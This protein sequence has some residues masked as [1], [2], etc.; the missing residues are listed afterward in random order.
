MPANPQRDIQKWHERLGSEGNVDSH[1]LLAGHPKT[2]P[3]EKVQR[4]IELLKNHKAAG[5]RN[6]YP[7]LEVLSLKVPEAAE[8][9][10]Q[11]GISVEALCKRIRKLRPSM[12]RIKVVVKKLH[13][14]QHLQRRLTAAKS[15]VRK[16][17]RE[18][19][20][21][22]FLDSKVMRME[23][24]E[25]YGWVDT[26]DEEDV[27]EFKRAKSRSSRVPT[28]NYYI[29]VGG[30]IGACDLRFCTGTTGMKASREG[31]TFKVS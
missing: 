15:R 3:D 14:P 24:D 30:Y 8:I 13:Q 5:E 25:V 12:K 11:S 4:L 23:V 6:P 21:Y 7:S 10:Q 19:L 22:I 2:C 31:I 28:L 1:S 9:I 18:Q 29:A 26:A 20:A 27:A 16:P 17:M